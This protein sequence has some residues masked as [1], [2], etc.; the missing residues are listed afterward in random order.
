[1]DAS[2]TLAL[3]LAAVIDGAEARPDAEATAAILEGAARFAAERLAPLAPVSDREGCALAGGRVRT[4]PG[5]AEAWRDFA[6]EGWAGLTA[7]AEAGGSAL[8]LAL[9]SAVQ[10]LTDAAHPAFGML[11]INAR[12]AIRLLE[13]HGPEAVRAAWLPR[14]ADGSWAATIAISEPG[15]GSDVGRLRTRAERG[16]DGTWRVTGEKCWISFG[17]HDLAARIGHFV[18]A[19]PRGAPPGTR[20]LSLFLVPSNREDGARNGVAALRLEEK[21][22]LHGSPTCTLAFEDAEAI[23]IGEVGRGLPTLFAMITAMR[24]GVAVQGAAVAGAAAGLAE[25]YARER[26]QG[27]DPAATPVP[28]AAH[29]EVRRLLL[30]ARA[31]TEAVRLIALQAAAW[32][33]AGDAGDAAAAARAALLLPVAK[34]LGAEAGFDNAHRAIQVLGGAGYVRDWPAERM[35][36]DARVFAL[37]EGT[38]AMQGL[39][40]LFR[41]TPA[42]DGAVLRDTLAQLAPAPDLAALVLDTAAALAEATPRAREGAAVP[43]LRLVG[44]AAADGLL[45][46]AAAR[47]GPLAPRYAALAAFHA[48]EAGSRAALLAAR[49]RRADLDAAYDAAFEP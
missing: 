20:G 19:R 17:D 28:I 16:A 10:E 13:R 21:L 14:L 2:A 7:P 34:T 31:A 6:A 49:C 33:D 4:A 48:A 27:G 36:R 45:R 46:R 3:L 26:L 30:A 35:L 11:A 18:L 8:P 1:M 9:A 41:R 37:Y 44:L 42:A 22:G 29:A 47:A 39:D 43:F 5:H 23:L 38:T 15:A 24:L 12:C 32:V 25:G 40:L